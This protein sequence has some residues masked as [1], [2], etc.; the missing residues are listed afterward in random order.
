VAHEEAI[1]FSCEEMVA[2]QMTL[3]TDGRFINVSGSSVNKSTIDN[4][5]VM[6]PLQFTG[7][8]DKNKKKIFEKDIARIKLDDETERIALVIYEEDEGGF[9]CQWA[10]SKDQHHVRLTCDVAFEAEVVGNEYENP[11]LLTTTPREESK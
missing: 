3:L 7:L 5:G 4:Y 10:W 2:D 9:I 8:R 6:I 11:E 1:M